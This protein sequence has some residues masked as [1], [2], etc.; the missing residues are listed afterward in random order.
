MEL[1]SIPTG[2]Y[3]NRGGRNN[4]EVHMGL[5]TP[6]YNITWYYIQHGSAGQRSNFW[7]T[8]GTP[9]PHSRGWVM[10]CL[11]CFVFEKINGVITCS[12]SIIYSSIN[13]NKTTIGVGA[14]VAICLISCILINLSLISS[15]RFKRYTCVLQLFLYRFWWLVGHGYVNISTP[16]TPASGAKVLICLLP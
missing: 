3:S 16:W 14:I 10:G 15:G 7:L 6:R 12:K 8:N 11:L 1:L 5:V 13:I 9:I 4:T 2:N